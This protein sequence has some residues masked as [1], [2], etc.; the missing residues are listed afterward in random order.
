MRIALVLFAVLAMAACSKKGG[1]DDCTA[2]VGTCNQNSI[3]CGIQLSCKD[4]QYGLKC[5]PPADGAKT[6]ACECVDNNVIGKKVELSYPWTGD[7]K[8][9]IK[10]ACEL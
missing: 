9:T 4:H 1:L 2:S 3:A 10:A 6:I 5:T 8:N 7:A